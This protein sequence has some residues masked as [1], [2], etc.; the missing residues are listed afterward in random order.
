MCLHK[1]VRRDFHKHRMQYPPVGRG[2]H[3]VHA[4]AA[5]SL[6][7][8]MTQAVSFYGWRYLHGMTV[9]LSL[10]MALLLEAFRH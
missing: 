3:T 1:D 8:F 7:R 10:L 2:R 9:L 5:A 6:H 4:H